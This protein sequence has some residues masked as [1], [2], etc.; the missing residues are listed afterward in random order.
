MKSPKMT[1]SDGDRKQPPAWV[2]LTRQQGWLL[3]SLLV[4]LVGVRIAGPWTGLWFDEAILWSIVA[5]ATCMACFSAATVVDHM[6]RQRSQPISGPLMAIGFRT[7]G[8]A[9]AAVLGGVM[10]EKGISRWFLANLVCFYAAGLIVHTWLWSRTLNR[11]DAAPSISPKST[12]Q[13]E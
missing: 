11:T 9:I 7:G 1:N 6:S 8:V 12:E 4:V 5:M 13:P 10:V 3:L 2:R